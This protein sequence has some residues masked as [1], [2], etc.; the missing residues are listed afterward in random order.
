MSISQLDPSLTTLTPI[1]Q[2]LVGSS[3]GTLI[4][5]PDVSGLTLAS[6]VSHRRPEDN[7]Q[8][9]QPIVSG[10]TTKKKQARRTKQE[11]IAYRASEAQAKKIKLRGK[12]KASRRKPGRQ[13]GRLSGSMPHNQDAGDTM[14]PATAPGGPQAIVPGASP[15]FNKEDY[16]NVCGYLE[17]E[18]NYT[19]LYGDGSKTSVGMTKVTKAA[20]YEMFAI[21]INNNSHGRLNL[22]GSQL[23]QRIDG[24]KK[25]FAKAKDWADNTGA[26]IEGG[27]DLPT[28]AELLE[29]RCPCYERMYAIFGGKENVTPLAQ[30]NSGVGANLYEDPGNTADA[31]DPDLSPEI[32]YSGW[33]DSQVDHQPPSGLTTPASQLDLTRCLSSL[34]RRSSLDLPNLDDPDF[35]Q[36]DEQLPP[37]LNLSGT[38]TIDPSQRLSALRSLT[39][40]NRASPGAQTRTPDAFPSLPGSGGGSARRP[41][42]NQRSTDASPAGPVREANAKAKTTLAS[43]FE[44]TNTEKFAY[45]KEHMAW[46]KEKE[47]ARLKWEKDRYDKETARVTSGTESQIKLAEMKMKSA[48]EWMDQGKSADEVA[49]LMKVVY[50]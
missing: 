4:S 34:N 10:Q 2:N 3:P 48:R 39:G 21:F 22:T 19:R 14:D 36:V 43:A 13:A 5:G 23:R 12:A 41:F 31:H 50:G 38:P 42:P 11:M 47:K 25:R 37:P 6:D 7:T 32:F 28:V 46:E 24:Y 35:G 30:F 27:E 15:P 18:A 29:K 8:S 44:S 20:A 33:D 45:L 1:D 40:A 26:G 17:E 9:P 16:E 49:Q